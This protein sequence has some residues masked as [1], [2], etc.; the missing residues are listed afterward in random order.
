MEDRR[1]GLILGASGVYHQ[2]AYSQEV[3]QVGNA[4]SF[5]SLPRMQV[6]S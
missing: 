1:N 2:S 6:D 4:G 5:A 3:S